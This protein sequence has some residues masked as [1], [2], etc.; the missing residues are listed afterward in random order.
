MKM[1]KTACSEML[2]FKLKT[3]ENN[4]EESIRHSK[5]GE[6]LNPRTVIIY[7]TASVSL[8]KVKW[9]PNIAEF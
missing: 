2:A 8:V 6:R 9:E 1:E 5:Q 4:S 7:F 3:P